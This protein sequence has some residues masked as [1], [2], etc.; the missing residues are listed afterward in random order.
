MATASPLISN[1]EPKAD[2][3]HRSRS[4]SSYDKKEIISDPETPDTNFETEKEEKPPTFYRRYRPYIL[5]G[6]AAAIL[7]WWISATVLPA[8]RHRW[9]ASVISLPPIWALL[10]ELGLF[11][12]CLLGVLSRM[13][14]LQSWPLP[15]SSL[16]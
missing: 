2:L 5:S 15:I 6:V 12:H 1:V 8:T 4:S 10:N 3:A 16:M 13:S 9:C 7:G 14:K 11:K